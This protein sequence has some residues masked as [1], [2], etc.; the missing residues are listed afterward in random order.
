MTMKVLLL[1]LLLRPDGGSSLVRGPL[2]APPAS[3]LL[4]HLAAV[5][6]VK[7][8]TS[9]TRTNLG[10]I[11]ALL[12]AWGS[13]VSLSGQQR[14]TPDDVIPLCSIVMC[15]ITSKCSTEPCA[16]P[17]LSCKLRWSRVSG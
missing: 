9:T 1:L 6:F 3:A 7:G 8:D 17:S 10:F 2:V 15:Y 4:S 13:K 5:G 16:M 11:K 14:C 12:Q